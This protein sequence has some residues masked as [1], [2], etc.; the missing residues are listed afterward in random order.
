MFLAQITMF[1]VSLSRKTLGLLDKVVS[2]F[3]FQVLQPSFR[4]T[5]VPQL[6]RHP[7][8]CSNRRHDPDL[9]FY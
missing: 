8:P 7:S 6:E 1:L 2:L 3:P 4:E 5:V 9:S